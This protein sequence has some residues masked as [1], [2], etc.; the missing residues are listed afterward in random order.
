M[1]PLPTSLQRWAVIADP[2]RLALAAALP[3]R[4]V[5][6]NSSTCWRHAAS[7]S[8][9]TAAIADIDGTSGIQAQTFATSALATMRK[10]ITKLEVVGLSA[11]AF[12]LNPVD[13]E[14]VELAVSSVNAI[15]HQGLPY[16]PARRHALRCPDRGLGSHRPSARAIY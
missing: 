13:W 2:D 10:A 11:G 12:V 4:V 1:R 9:G 15:E 7:L 14:S 3:G 16:D 6:S 5:A 8:F